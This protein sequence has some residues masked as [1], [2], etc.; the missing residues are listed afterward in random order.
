MRVLAPSVLVFEAIVVALFIPVAYFTGRGLSGSTAAWLGAGLVLLCI[1]A[2]A[3]VGRSWGVTLGWVVQVLVLACGFLVWDMFILGAIF[4]GLWWAA[5]H[6]GRKVEALKAER[7]Q[8]H[9][10]APQN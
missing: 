9:G 8:G 5:I 3:M 6:Y 2:A 10:P 4:T 7:E 1:V